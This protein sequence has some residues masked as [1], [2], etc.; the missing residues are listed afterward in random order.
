MKTRKILVSKEESGIILKKQGR[1][2]HAGTI[3]NHMYDIEFIKHVVK[4]ELE[5][6]NII[7]NTIYKSTF[8]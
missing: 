3:S 4:H 1:L 6:K 7:S 8:T 5:S 2:L